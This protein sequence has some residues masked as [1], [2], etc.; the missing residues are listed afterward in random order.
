MAKARKYRVMRFYVHQGDM[1]FQELKK[2]LITNDPTYASRY[3][4]CRYA[5]RKRYED[6]ALN[7]AVVESEYCSI[8]PA[9]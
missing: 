1:T 2:W 9:R 8:K 4:Q 3:E 6:G 7:W 5:Y